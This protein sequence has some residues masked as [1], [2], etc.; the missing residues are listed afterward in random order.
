MQADDPKKYFGDVVA[1]IFDEI[2]KKHKDLLDLEDLIAMTS[3]SIKLQDVM[4]DVS[5]RL[6]ESWRDEMFKKYSQF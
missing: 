1:G 6:E 2:N 5:E 3:T 4:N